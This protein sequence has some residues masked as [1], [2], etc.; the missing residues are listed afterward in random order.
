MDPQVLTG[1]S[2]SR[3]KLKIQDTQNLGNSKPGKLKIRETQNLRNSKAGKLKIHE[4][5]NLGNKIVMSFSQ[6]NF[7]LEDT[8]LL[9]LLLL[10]LLSFITC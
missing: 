3:W 9:L 5:Q 7:V 10:L 1:L 8:F 4:A 2:V 6:N